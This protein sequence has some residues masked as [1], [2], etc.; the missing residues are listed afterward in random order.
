MTGV[1]PKEKKTIKGTRHL[2]VLI[3]DN[4]FTRDNFPFILFYFN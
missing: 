4:I 1:E 3:S 2:R